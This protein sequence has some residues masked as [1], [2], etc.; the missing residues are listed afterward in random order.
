MLAM[1]MRP[2]LP[3][4]L[5]AA[6]YILL[7]GHNLPGG[8]FIAGLITGVVLIL[9]YLAVGIEVTSARLRLDHLRLFALGLGLAVGTGLASMAFGAPFLTGTHGYV[10][11]PLVGKTH[12]ASALVFDLG[13]YLAVVATVLLVLSELGRLSQRERAGMAGSPGGLRPPATRAE[14]AVAGTPT[15]AGEGRA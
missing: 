13:V 14:A 11:S 9:Q 5:T 7:R 6:F 2:L 15:A 12:L 3:L 4:G 8:G 10:P 1:L